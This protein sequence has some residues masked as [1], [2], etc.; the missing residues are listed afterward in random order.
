MDRRYF[1]PLEAAAVCHFSVLKRLSALGLAA[2]L[3]LP[4]LLIIPSKLISAWLA[5][6][7]MDVVFKSRALKLHPIPPGGSECGFL[8][9]PFEAG[10]RRL[11]VKLLAAGGSMHRERDEAPGQGQ[12]AAE[13]AFDIPIPGIRAD[14]ARID[15]AA[16]DAAAPPEA[17]DAAALR[18]RLDAMPPATSSRRGRGSGDPVNLVIIAEY[19]WLLS[20]FA[21]QWD[22]TEIITLA[23]CAR[24]ARAF[25]L[26]SEYRYS[27]VSPLCLFGRPQDIALQRI[28]QSI[29]ERL[30]L[31]LWYTPLRFEGVPVWVGQ[32][33]RDIGV[34]FTPRTWN[35]TTHR[36]DPDVDEAREYVVSDL[37]D[38]G[39][40]QALAYVAGVAPCPPEQPRR[41]LTGDPYYTDGRRAVLYLAPGPTTPRYVAFD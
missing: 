13:F 29:N 5:N 25:L 15:F 6:R 31:R 40:V 14:H 26:G 37:F 38:A 33:S 32:I 35:L 36:I 41:N 1:T 16:L 28:R 20:A 39:R 2:W 8:Y 30:H 34:R 27:P 7:R 19:D 18:A 24:T 11:V 10:N 12:T 9:I 23:S 4:V 22:E 17:C 21:E 3:V